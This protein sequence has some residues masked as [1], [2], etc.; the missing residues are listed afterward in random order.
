MTATAMNLPITN[1]TRRNRM[2]RFGIALA[3]GLVAAMTA[4][5][6]EPPLKKVEWKGK[7][8]PPADTPKRIATFFK[9]Q[10]KK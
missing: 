3:V 9:E 7:H 2:N 10:A 1:R 5:A 8:M 6:A 4:V